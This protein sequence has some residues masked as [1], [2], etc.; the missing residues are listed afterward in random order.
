MCLHV[1]KNIFLTT[2][3]TQNL[4]IWL[5]NPGLLCRNKVGDDET[6]LIWGRG[7]TK[8]YK[9]SDII[10]PLNRYDNSSM[11]N[12]GGSASVHVVGWDTWTSEAED[13][14]L[15]Q[16]SWAPR[17]VGA[18]LGL[19]IARGDNDALEGAVDKDRVRS[20]TLVRLD[21]AELESQSSARKL[22]CRS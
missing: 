11:D 19:R 6:F 1:S 12:D 22:P 14:G 21:K 18:G 7:E 8:I 17:S 13:V 10:Q 2:D 20:S 5:Q 9:G 4:G 3:E 16:G 15:Q